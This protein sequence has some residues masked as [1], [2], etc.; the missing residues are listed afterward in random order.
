LLFQKSLELWN[1]N[2]GSLIQSKDAARVYEGSSDFYCFRE[3]VGYQFILKLNLAYWIQ[4]KIRLFQPIR[5][6]LGLIDLPVNWI[7]SLLQNRWN[8]RTKPLKQNQLEYYREIVD[9]D[10]IQFVNE[11]NRKAFLRR[12]VA[13]LNTIVKFPTSISA[14][15]PDAVKTRYFFATKAKQFE[16]YYFKSY[17][18]MDLSGLALINLDGRELKLLYYFSKDDSNH[19]NI[20]NIVLLHAKAL[21]VEI[22]TSYDDR[23]NKFIKSSGFPR[24]FNRSQVRKSFLPVQYRSLVNDELLIFDGDGA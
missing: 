6:F 20:F 24:L 15:L 22:I 8:A 19:D 4:K 13:E 10:T 3:S 9:E 17:V 2:I 1:G 16:Y 14:P 21:K 7:L 23:F 12:G 18:N 5:F 11:R